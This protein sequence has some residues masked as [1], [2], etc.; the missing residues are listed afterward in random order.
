MTMKLAIGRRKNP[1][2]RSP[3]CYCQ[4]TVL[5]MGQSGE[6]AGRAGS[7]PASVHLKQGERQCLTEMEEDQEAVP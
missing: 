2:R 6:V 4:Q 5:D 1:L 3:V 7:N